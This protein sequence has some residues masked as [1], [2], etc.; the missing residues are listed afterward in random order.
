MIIP[1]EIM[2]DTKEQ[3]MIWRYQIQ[4]KLW[5]ERLDL[6]L[7][8][9]EQ[10]MLSGAEVSRVEDSVNRLCIAYGADH[11][12]VLS[13][14]T[15]LIVTVYMKEYGSITQTRRTTHF[16]SDMNRLDKMN[17]LSRHI[18]EKHL[19]LEEARREYDDIIKERPYRFLLRIVF[20]IIVAFSFA[21]FFGGDF[22]D[23]AVS[24]AI[25]V[26]FCFFDY[27]A[28]RFGVNNLL[29]IFI[30]SLVG[31]FLASASVEMGLAHSIS[32]VSIGDVMILIPGIVLTN[33]MRDMFGGDTITGGIRFIEALL[34]AATIAFGFT[35]SQLMFNELIGHAV[36]S[37][38]RNWPLWCGVVTEIVTAFW[39]SFG[40]ASLF[41]VRGNRII[42]AGVGGALAWVIYL[43]AASFAASFPIR[44]VFAAVG[45]TFYAEIMA[46][47]LKAPATI[48]LVSAIMPLVP[49]GSLYETMSFAVRKD[50]TSFETMGIKTLAT[51]LSIAVGMLVTASVRKVFARVK[52]KKS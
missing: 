52:N 40:Y 2:P 33:S 26:A 48:F 41:N 7:D 36:V 19:S 12:E 32:K 46:R 25:A 18:C 30:M 43:I 1:T 49:G 13:I 24:G 51:A 29:S 31:G 21:L 5:D 20:Y 4:R 34:T 38:E 39:G 14:T 3:A 15:S 23:A 16:V 37:T 17:A 35:T 45:A 42:P 9:G 44:F 22:T 6:I 11:A 28:T 50:L 27:F 8:I 10:M 47:K